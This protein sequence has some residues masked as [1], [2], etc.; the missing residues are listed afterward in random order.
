MMGFYL[1]GQNTQQLYIGTC[2]LFKPAIRNYLK[3]E[4][5]IIGYS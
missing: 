1:F 4:Y 2:K 3:Q 5:L